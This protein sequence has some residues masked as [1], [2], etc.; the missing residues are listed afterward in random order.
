MSPILK[1]KFHR[2]FS[3]IELSIV[4]L[5]IGILIAG[6]TQGSRLVRQSRFAIAKSLTQNASVLS[7]PNMAVWFETTSDNSITSATNGTSPEDGD[8]ISSWNDINMQSVNQ[9]IASST[10][11]FRPTYV[12]SGINNLPSVKFSGAQYLFSSLAAGGV[13]P[14][15]AGSTDFTYI[16]VWKSYSASTSDIFDQNSTT[17]IA[18]KRAGFI[19]LSSTYGFC[20]ESND[21]FNTASYSINKTMASIMIVSATSASVSTIKIYDNISTYSGTIGPT[22]GISNSLFYIGAKATNQ[23]EKFNGLISEIII[24]KRALKPTEVVDVK[25]YLAKKYGIAIL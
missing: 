20:G 22:T 6:V 15:D 7:M 12:I 19:T 18:G 1:K 8:L 4:V 21:W 10:G 24:F 25:S 23:L 9:M 5:I 17:Q 3:L 2:A 11:A 13:I 14:L 16:A